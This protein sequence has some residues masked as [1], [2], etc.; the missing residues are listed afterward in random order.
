[1]INTIT[2]GLLVTGICAAGA[3]GGALLS[4]HLPIAAAEPV[5]GAAAAMMS[6]FG[7][8]AS[9]HGGYTV[10]PIHDEGA[11]YSWTAYVAAFAPDGRVTIIST[12]PK[13]PE[14][15]GTIVKQTKI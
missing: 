6:T 1:M 9:G 14:E 3:L 5:T 12:N 4:R 15:L 13:K 11:G 8:G 7:Q 2:R 10:I